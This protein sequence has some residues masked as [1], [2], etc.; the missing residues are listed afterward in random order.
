MR[1]TP[2]NFSL[3]QR[4]DVAVDVDSYLFFCELSRSI[5]DHFTRARGYKTFFMLNSAETKIYLLINVKMPTIV[6]ILTFISRIN[7]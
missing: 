2:C 4:T 6:G 5:S 1:L 3:F 7:Y